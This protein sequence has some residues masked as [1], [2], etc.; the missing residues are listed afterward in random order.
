MSDKKFIV[1][2]AP[3]FHDGGSIVT[4]SCHT[5]LAALPAVIFGIIQ[6]GMPAVGVVSLSVSCAMIFEYLLN[7]VTKRPISIGDGNAALIGLLFAM[8]LPATSPWWMVVIGIFVAILVGKQIYGGIGG[9]P[10]NPALVAIAICMLS[11]K[12]IFDFDEALRHYEF[13]FSAAYPLASLKHFGVSAV[14]GFSL[15]QLLL[16]R[17]TGAIGSTFGIGLIAGGIYLIVRGFIRWEISVSYLLGVF[18]TA[19]IFNLASPAKYGGAFF[20]L[21]T[22]YTL[23]TAFFL[24]TDDSSSPVNLIPMILYGLGAGVVTMLI[25]NIG[26]FVDG[27]VF[28]VLLFN[29]ANPLLDRIRPK[30]LGKVT[31]HA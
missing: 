11:W 9:N 17:Q 31:E 7:R 22:G 16:G 6:Y 12:D 10:F 26:S 14:E 24:A 15:G 5:I 8:L 21:F 19:L 4:R 23:I 18:I 28:A 27:A 2:H 13:G 30:A 29:I 20:H 25:R 3:F 1:S